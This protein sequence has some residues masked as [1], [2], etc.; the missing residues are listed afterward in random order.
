MSD[1]DNKKYRG[2]RAYLNDFTQTELGEYIYSGAVYRYS[3]NHKTLLLRSWVLGIIAAG[4]IIANGCIPAAGMINC[5]YVIAPYVVCFVA[6][7]SV[8]WALCKLTSGGDPIREYNYKSSVKALPV[9]CL[10]SFVAAL[11]S[12][13]S[14]VIYLILNGTSKE[15]T[16]PCSVL[17]L[18]LDAIIAGAVWLLRI[19]ISRSEW[20]QI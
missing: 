15:G 13:V 1:P 4:A 12:I 16:V 6:N 20:N 7:V 2:R 8:I 5:Y 11:V 17:F 14:E 3:G 9:R 18:A 10:I 19:L